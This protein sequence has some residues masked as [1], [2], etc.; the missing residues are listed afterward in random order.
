MYDF[1]NLG[2][3]RRTFMFYGIGND[4]P[5][6]EERML[7]EAASEELEIKRYVEEAL[8]GPV[9]PK[10]APLFFQDTRLL[11][12]M[13]RNGVVYVNLS[14]AAGLP[15]LEGAPLRE[16]EVCR[17]LRTLGA[18]IQRN[19]PA[20]QEVKLFINGSRVS[21][22][23]P[24]GRGFTALV[25]LLETAIKETYPR[26][27]RHLTIASGFFACLPGLGLA[28]NRVISSSDQKLKSS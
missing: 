23:T 26:G 10:T 14:E 15:P 9:S 13:Y 11:S 17:S 24:E 25:G 2:S 3:L 6:V 4:T 1:L 21:C 19:F 16:G 12:F 27:V 8:L 20:V 18:G 28:R 5:A 22:S 7:P